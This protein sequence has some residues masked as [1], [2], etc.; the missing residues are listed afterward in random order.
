MAIRPIAVVRHAEERC[1][2]GYMVY[3]FHG[4]RGALHDGDVQVERAV[5]QVLKELGS[6][7]QG[8]VRENVWKLG[9]GVLS[10]HQLLPLGSFRVLEVDELLGFEMDVDVVEPACTTFFQ[11]AI[12]SM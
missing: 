10:P 4:R 8:V 7:E 9:R 12:A 11:L 2:P 6:K 3:V 1:E 5:I